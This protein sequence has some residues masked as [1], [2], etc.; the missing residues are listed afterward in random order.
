MTM[1]STPVSNQI[2]TSVIHSHKATLPLWPVD[3]TQVADRTS[4]QSESR[5][6]EAC[7]HGHRKVPDAAVVVD[8]ISV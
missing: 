2:K 4:Y 3:G 8:V 6:K 1:S 5:P 7:P